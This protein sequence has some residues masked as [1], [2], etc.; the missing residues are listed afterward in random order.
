MYLARTAH[1]DLLQLEVQAAN[2]QVVA[3]DRLHPSTQDQVYLCLALSAKEQLQVSFGVE[4]PTMIDDVFVH[5]ENHK[6]NPTADL[7]TDF[8]RQGH[9][10]ILFLSLIHI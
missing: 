7:L 4:L 1:S 9:Q 8:V 6:V 2:G 5:I 3:F 10:V